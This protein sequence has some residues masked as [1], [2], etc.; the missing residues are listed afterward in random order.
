MTDIF[1]ST[2]PNLNNYVIQFETEDMTDDAVMPKYKSTITDKLNIEDSY[3]IWLSRLD[4]YITQGVTYFKKIET[5]DN[6]LQIIQPPGDNDT[7]VIPDILHDFIIKAL[8]LLNEYKTIGYKNNPDNKLFNIITPEQDN[9]K[10]T[11]VQTTNMN[12]KSKTNIDDYT[13][14]WGQ[15]VGVEKKTNNTNTK[16]GNTV[17]LIMSYNSKTINFGYT[18]TKHKQIKQSRMTSDIENIIYTKIDKIADNH[19]VQNLFNNKAVISELSKYYISNNNDNHGAYI[20][21][22]TD[23]ISEINKLSFNTT[24]YKLLQK[25]PHT[26]LKRDIGSTFINILISILDKPH[27]IIGSRVKLT[28][29]TNIMKNI[30][31]PNL[32]TYIDYITVIKEHYLSDSEIKK[33]KI[34]TF[35]NFVKIMLESFNNTSPSKT[36]TSELSYE[37]AILYLVCKYHIQ[38]IFPKKDF[39]L[40]FNTTDNTGIIYDD[41]DSI[42]INPDIM[43]LTTEIKTVLNNNNDAR[44]YFSTPEVIDHGHVYPI[45][46]NETR[47]EFPENYKEIQLPII[48]MDKSHPQFVD[49]CFVIHSYSTSDKR[50]IG[51]EYKLNYIVYVWFTILTI[52]TSIES[53][54]LCVIKYTVPFRNAPDC[55]KVYEGYNNIINN[56]LKSIKNKIT[57]AINNITTFTYG[58]K[59]KN[60]L[61]SIMLDQFFNAKSL[62]D[63]QNQLQVNQLSTL[64]SPPIDLLVPSSKPT[65]FIGLCTDLASAANGINYY[66]SRSESDRNENS[67]VAY[68]SKLKK[69]AKCIW[70]QSNTINFF[71]QKSINITIANKILEIILK[72]E[73]LN[74][75][76]VV[77]KVV[78]KK[79]KSKLASKKKGGV[80]N[81]RYNTF[82]LSKRTLKNKL[83]K[84]NTRRLKNKLS[85]NRDNRISMYNLHNKSKRAKLF[86]NNRF[87]NYQIT[88]YNTMYDIFYMSDNVYNESPDYFDSLFKQYNDNGHLLFSIYSN[89]FITI[90]LDKL[91]EI[92][93]TTNDIYNN[94]I[95]YNIANE[96]LKHQSAPF[97]SNN[98]YGT[99][100]SIDGQI[101]LSDDLFQRYKS[102]YEST[103]KNK[104]KNKIKSNDIQNIS[105]EKI[106]NSKHNSFI[107]N[108]KRSRESRNSMI[109]PSATFDSYKSPATSAGYKK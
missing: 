44:I 35:I 63:D 56:H 36:F 108:L 53:S 16:I 9:I 14:Y 61:T 32:E 64:L 54:P 38:D 97:Y 86:D 93:N 88:T 8:K 10:E 17:F 85:N 71:S 70:A 109:L 28:A 59:M 26:L 69:N 42:I 13:K 58:D 83:S 30:I 105:D 24:N 78:S 92:I 52:T 94:D 49:K 101:K 55:A 41:T 27:D 39:N 73:V 57:T 90:F 102:I 75:K 6:S 79:K 4:D 72:K 50:N 1:T 22:Y 76:P 103:N 19:S 95:H 31:I 51:D 12:T 67:I 107:K 98:L 68:Y 47:I 21:I 91:E 104:N 11:R 37:N 2:N 29:Q 18:W 62:Q 89:H 5:T 100:R 82:Q 40:T 45:I 96:L 15:A 33:D 7:C 34:T 106:I 87:D 99:D 43:N 60:V 74:P 65:T 25:K 23:N 77:S 80:L 84:R 20:E 66:F 46:N 81:M 3:I 48:D